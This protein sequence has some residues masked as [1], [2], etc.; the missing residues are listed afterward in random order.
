VARTHVAF[1]DGHG[2]PPTGEAICQ[3]REVQF[4]TD[5]TQ[6]FGF[7][8]VKRRTEGGL[9]EGESGVELVDAD[10]CHRSLKFLWAD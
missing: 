9:G 2:H 10:K 6:V 4:C 8:R 5:R 1:E 3:S 7:H